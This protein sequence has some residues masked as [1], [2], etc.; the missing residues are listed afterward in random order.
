MIIG[1]RPQKMHVSLSLSSS[2]S[3]VG[4]RGLDVSRGW[5]PPLLL[6]RREA[7]SGGAAC[8]VGAQVEGQLRSCL[9]AEGS[10]ASVAGGQRFL[11]RR[12]AITHAPLRLGERKAG[13]WSVGGGSPGAVPRG[14]PS[15]QARGKPQPPPPPLE[16]PLSFPFFISL[17]S[18]CKLSALVPVQTPKHKAP[19]HVHSPGCSPFLKEPWFSFHCSS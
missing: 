18:I 1:I 10:E 17:S 12:E 5:L 14:L 4:M 8:R 11:E 7:T 2:L 3:E 6:G 13:A 19:S 16:Q 9:Q 15:L